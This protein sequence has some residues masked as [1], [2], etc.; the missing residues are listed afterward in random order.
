VAQETKRATITWQQDLKFTGGAPGSPSVIID[1]D[2]V[3]GPGPMLAL[4]LAAASC[5]GSDVVVI[6]QKMRVKLRE[7]RIEAEGTRREQEPRRYIA[8]HLDY[9]M[10]GEGLDEAR[11]RRAID[12]S[13]EKYCSVV[14]S[15]APDIAI[16]YAL[17]LA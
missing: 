5:T 15:L 16:T 10:A 3:S 11:A 14:H 4:L 2:N 8:L 1:G 12:L 7:L 9:R 6:L 13:L 17:S